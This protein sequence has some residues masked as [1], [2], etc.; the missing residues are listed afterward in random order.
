MSI[1]VGDLH[2]MGE[3][4]IFGKTVDSEAEDLLFFNSILLGKSVI[5]INMKLTFRVYRT[6]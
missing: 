3:K 4:R 6:K 2:G 1:G 5:N